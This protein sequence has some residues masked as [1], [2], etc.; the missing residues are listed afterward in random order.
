MESTSSHTSSKASEIEISNSKKSKYINKA[1]NW[2]LNLSYHKN[3]G[4]HSLQLAISRGWEHIEI[5]DKGDIIKWNMGWA[6][7]GNKF[8]GLVEYQK[9]E[10]IKY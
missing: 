8:H 7:G 6:P 10:L 4:I 9:E 1:C 5:E 3:S 2:A